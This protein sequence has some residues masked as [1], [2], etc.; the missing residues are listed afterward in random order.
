MSHQ[1]EGNKLFRV[2]KE[3]HDIHPPHTFWSDNFDRFVNRQLLYQPDSLILR[4]FIYQMHS[5]QINCQICFSL[6]TFRNSKTKK[7]RKRNLTIN[8]PNGQ[9][10]RIHD[11]TRH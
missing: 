8:E 2:S 10:L 9:D 6:K 5:L 11:G 1:L 4:P 3:Y 7:K